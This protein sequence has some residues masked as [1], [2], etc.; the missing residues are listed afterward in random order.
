[1]KDPRLRGRPPLYFL[2]RACKMAKKLRKPRP[3]KSAGHT[4]PHVRDAPQKAPVDQLRARLGVCIKNTRQQLGIAQSQL[5]VRSELTQSQISDLETGKS[6]ASLETLAAVSC[7]LNVRMATLI[8]E[9]EATAYPSPSILPFSRMSDSYDARLVEWGLAK[10]YLAEYVAFLFRSNYQSQVVGIDGGTMNQFLADSIGRDIVKGQRT[11]G[12]IITNHIGVPERVSTG[13]NAPSVFVT[14]GVFRTDRK[15]LIG[16]HVAL[17]LQKFQMAAAVV[18]INGFQF[19]SMFTKAGMENDLKSAFMSK[20]NDIIV[21]IDPPKWGQIS[22]STLQNV[23][24]LVKNDK[25]VILLGVY[26]VDAVA[27]ISTTDK[28]Q[29][30]KMTSAFVDNVKSMITKFKSKLKVS[31]ATVALAPPGTVPHIDVFP[32]TPTVD[33]LESIDVKCRS[34]GIKCGVVAVA[35]SNK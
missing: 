10:H 23:D 9:A 31:F 32:L 1:M 4:A 34:E 35:I 21:A 19:P 16:E 6:S 27:D 22:G 24:D 12:M 5:A 8:Y 26:P 33:A 29:I 7:A 25:R 15:T 11:I 30:K 13:Q 14:G 28:A 17:S 3:A 2:G 18:G 20:S